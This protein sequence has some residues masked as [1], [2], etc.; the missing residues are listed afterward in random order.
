MY[1]SLFSHCG[2]TAYYSH[3]TLLYLGGLKT[4]PEV[5]NLGVISGKCHF[6]FS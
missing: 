4:K 1:D 6:G 2:A 3:S 5:Y